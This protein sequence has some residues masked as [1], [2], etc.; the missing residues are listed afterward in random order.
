MAGLWRPAGLRWRDCE[1]GRD[2]D[3][4]IGIVFFFRDFGMSP[5]VCM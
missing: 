2:E 4:G 1:D 3:G 5:Y